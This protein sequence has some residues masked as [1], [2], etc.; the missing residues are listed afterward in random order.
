MTAAFDNLTGHWDDRLGQLRPWDR[1]N[2]REDIER[3]E[4]EQLSGL[5]TVLSRKVN[6]RLSAK[7]HR[8]D[9]EDILLIA[10]DLAEVFRTHPRGADTLQRVRSTSVGWRLI[11]L[12]FQG[13]SYGE[14]VD[15]LEKIK[16]SPAKSVNKR[17]DFALTKVVAATTDAKGP[18]RST[19]NWGAA[20]VKNLGVH[21]RDHIPV[22]LVTGNG[23]PRIRHGSTFALLPDDASP[24]AITMRKA[25]KILASSSRVLRMK[26]RFIVKTTG[27][28]HGQAKRISYAVKRGVKL[29]R[30][31]PR[32]SSG[33]RA[34]T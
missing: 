16:A 12:A 19:L 5:A 25:L 34:T 30:A 33:G 15:A 26:K 11:K 6:A 14:L 32:T 10:S 24:E 1:K 2:A 7:P 28:K 4:D 9:I 23:P 17:S 21:P 27:T 20:L 8:D 3:L 13:K 31:K 18:G 29:R 22:Q